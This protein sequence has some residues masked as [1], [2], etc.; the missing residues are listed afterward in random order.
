MHNGLQVK[1]DAICL[2]SSNY[3]SHKI[4]EN[5]KKIWRNFSPSNKRNTAN[6]T[7]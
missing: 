3:I 6:Y 7:P 1:I 5:R 4:T 2:L